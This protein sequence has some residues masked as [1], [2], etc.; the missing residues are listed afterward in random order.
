MPLQ[1]LAAAQAELSRGDEVLKETLERTRDAEALRADN[2]DKLAAAKLATEPLKQAHLQAMAESEQ[3]EKRLEQLRDQ[4]RELERKVSGLESRI[5]TLQATSPQTPTTV[6]EVLPTANLQPITTVISIRIGL[7]KALAAA[8][9]GLIDALSISE[10]STDQQQALLQAQLPRTTVMIA[11]P[12]SRS[13]HLEA[14]LPPGACWLIDELECDPAYTAVLSRLLSDVV[15]ADSPSQAEEIVTADP[16]LRAVTTS[17]VMLG[18]A[19]LTVGEGERTALQVA[20]DIESATAELAVVQTQLK[21]LAGT[22]AGAKQATEEAR[23]AAAR[24]T[25]AFS[26]TQQ[27]Y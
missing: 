18:E 20:A 16:R 23:I 27:C 5:E 25:N 11:R 4:Q 9:G 2:V 24:A 14:V 21:E 17:G 22:F 8:L 1:S 19:W 26:R 13:W 15:L 12:T 10:L 7:E 3:S 6:Q